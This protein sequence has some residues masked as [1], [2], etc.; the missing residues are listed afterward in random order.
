MRRLAL[1]CLGLAA[2]ATGP[3]LEEAMAAYDGREAA[4]RT[5]HPADELAYRDCARTALE[6][7]VVPALPYAEL[8]VGYRALLAEDRRL[9]ED[10]AAGRLSQGEYAARIDAATARLAEQW[11]REAEADRRTR[12]SAEQVD[13]LQRQ[14]T[15]VDDL[16]RRGRR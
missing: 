10:V 7:L 9:A 8:R 13:A 15:I 6:E 3:S 14:L 4:C 5:A 11:R 16:V 1:L 12:A 2:C